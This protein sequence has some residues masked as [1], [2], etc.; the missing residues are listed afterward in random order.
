MADSSELDE[1]RRHNLAW[2][3]MRVAQDHRNRAQSE[4]AKRGYP[5]MAPALS[6]VTVHLPLEGGRLTD[7][8]ARA[9]VTKQSMGQLVDDMERLGYVERQCDP[10]DRR[11]KRIQFTDAGL[12]L[13]ADAREILAEIWHDYA[14]TLG[15][16]RLATLRDSLDILLRDI[17]QGRSADRVG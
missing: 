6:M 8:A 2:L 17:E 1:F 12:A 16:R 11:A 5:G 14:A 10:D 13:L 4:F 9:G 3:L 7:L 15:E